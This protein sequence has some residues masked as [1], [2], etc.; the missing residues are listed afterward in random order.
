LSIDAT[1]KPEVKQLLSAY[2]AVVGGAYPLDHII[3]V[4]DKTSKDLRDLIE[5]NESPRLAQ[6]I[7]MVVVAFQ[8]VPIGMCPYFILVAR[9]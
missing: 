5:N 6:E 2:K 4:Q 8:I 7:N 9:P 3:S 1:K